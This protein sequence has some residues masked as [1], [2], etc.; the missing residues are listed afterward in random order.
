[1]KAR[2]LSG[3]LLV[4]LVVPLNSCPRT[5]EISPGVWLLS[6]D[7][8]EI[9]VE[10]LANGIVQTPF[11]FPPEANASFLTGSDITISWTQDGSRF[12]LTIEVGSTVSTVYGGTVDSSTSI[13]DGTWLGAGGTMSSTWR[14]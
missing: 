7:D 9:G 10:L 1:M 11:P 8:L 12:T 3:L 4:A 13:V 5:P 14:G 2:I 6:T